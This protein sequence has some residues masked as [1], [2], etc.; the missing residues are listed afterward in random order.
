MLIAI[1]NTVTTIKIR[2]SLKL[3]YREPHDPKRICSGWLDHSKIYAAQ[4]EGNPQ[5]V[6]IVW[7]RFCSL[8]NDQHHIVRLLYRITAAVSAFFIVR[9]HSIWRLPIHPRSAV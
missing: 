5:S 9:R 6:Y 4:T 7:L 3:L 8:A 2:I 1:E